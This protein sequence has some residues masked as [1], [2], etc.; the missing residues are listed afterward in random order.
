MQHLPDVVGMI[1]NAKPLLDDFRYPAARPQIGAKARRQWTIANDSSQLL[2]LLSG[3]LWR[4]SRDGFGRQ[5]IRA[6]CDDRT[7]PTL[8]ARQV[9]ADQSSDLRVTLAIL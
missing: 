3:E 2:P 5:D 1:G 9:C 8:D 7:F 6:A 4:P